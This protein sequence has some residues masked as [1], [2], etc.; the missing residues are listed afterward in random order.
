MLSRFR[1]AMTGMHFKSYNSFYFFNGR[2]TFRYS[3]L[4]Y[5]VKYYFILPDICS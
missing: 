3:I 2:F 4:S 5:P 1:I